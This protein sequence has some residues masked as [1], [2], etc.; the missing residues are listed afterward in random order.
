MN[1]TFNVTG[2]VTNMNMN[3]MIELDQ[4]IG[5]HSLL[6]KR[7]KYTS[8]ANVCKKVGLHTLQEHLL[9]GKHLLD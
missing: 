3:Y 9:E 4:F 8:S 2:K 6:T 1:C 7:I 5:L